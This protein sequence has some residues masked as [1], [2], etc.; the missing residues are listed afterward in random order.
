M[1]GAADG[2]ALA[3]VVGF[4]SY[5]QALE[6]GWTYLKTLPTRED[7]GA[8]AAR[9]RIFGVSSDSD[10]QQLR[11]A[12]AEVLEGESNATDGQATLERAG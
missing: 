5:N 3:A 10:L 7:F 9:A 2:R 8:V 6:R 12:F 1:I 11:A 4:R